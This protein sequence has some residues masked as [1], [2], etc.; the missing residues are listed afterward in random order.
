MFD[1]QWTPTFNSAQGKAA[2]DFFVGTLKS[3]APPAV[4]SISIDRNSASIS[5]WLASSSFKPS[6]RCVVAKSAGAREATSGETPVR[7][8]HI[9]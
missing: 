2:A 9:F 5:R 7:P 3:I 1:D 4:F 8:L 6:A